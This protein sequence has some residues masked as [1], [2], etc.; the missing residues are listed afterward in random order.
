MSKE[1]AFTVRHLTAYVTP[2]AHC[3][4]ETVTA[5]IEKHLRCPKCC[6][7]LAATDEACVLVLEPKEEGKL[8]H[9]VCLSK[10]QTNIVP[11]YDDAAQPFIKTLAKAIVNERRV[12]Q[13][14]RAV[15]VRE[16]PKG[17]YNQISTKDR[18]RRPCRRLA[19]IGRR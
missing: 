18:Q 6:Q 7:A 15:I 3:S 1:L 19:V 13:S 10:E 5:F 9:L 12:Q 17:G 4:R 11:P 8:Y 14:Y 16:L 2:R